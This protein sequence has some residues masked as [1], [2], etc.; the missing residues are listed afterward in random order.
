MACGTWSANRRAAI[1]RTSGERR[2]FFVSGYFC[3][4]EGCR[5]PLMHRFG[6]PIWETKLNN[7]DIPEQRNPAKT[8]PRT[9]GDIMRFAAKGLLLAIGLVVMPVTISLMGGVRFSGAD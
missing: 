4:F 2:R 8:L 3:L 7:P 6:G 1:A 9:E 5:L